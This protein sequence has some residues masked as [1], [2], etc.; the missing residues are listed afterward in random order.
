MITISA[1]VIVKNEAKNIGRWLACMR[2]LADEIIVVDTGS[3]DATIAL[4]KGGGAK[5]FSFAWCDDFSAAKNYALEQAHG[6]WILFPDAD[7]FFTEESIPCVRPCIEKYHMNHKVAGFYCRMVDYDD[8]AGKCGGENGQ[9]R[10]FRNLRT[11]RYGGRIHEA[12]LVPP[13]KRVQF[14]P[15]LVLYHTGYAGPLSAEKAKRNLRILQQEAAEAGG[16]QP[17]RLIYFMDCY[18]SMEAYEQA[19]AYGYRVIEAEQHQIGMEGHEYTVLVNSLMQLHR[20]ASEIENVLEKGMEKYPELPGLAAMRGLLYW[21]RQ[22][23]IGAEKYLRRSAELKERP[24]KDHFVLYTDNTIGLMPYVYLYLGR[25]ALLRLRPD[26]AVQAFA[27]GLQ[28]KKEDVR[29]FQNLY[30]CIAAWAPTD[31][32][33]LLNGLYDK[34]KDAAWLADCLWEL[35]AG[36]LYLYYARLAGEK[37]ST[38]R[39]YLAIGRYDAAAVQLASDL[40]GLFRLGIASDLRE[41]RGPGGALDALLPERYRK[42][43]QQ[44]ENMQD[45]IACSIRRMMAAWKHRKTAESKGDT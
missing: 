15:E 27:K 43:W 18:H 41:G 22:D 10:I 5:V 17:D 25:L 16:E 20:P 26:E 21:D 35:G 36:K 42:A 13:S 40:D 23:Y 9:V 39:S 44:P 32:A 33:E 45:G 14:A 2:R 38:V 3:T 29:L 37:L 31:Q 11:L 30:H 1:C 4:A 19:A 7:E 28:L 8:A 34:E 12:I 6:E 24:Q